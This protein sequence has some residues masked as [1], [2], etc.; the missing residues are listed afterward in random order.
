M[1]YGQKRLSLAD[2]QIAAQKLRQEIDK[3]KNL[4]VSQIGS[5]FWVIFVNAY[6]YGGF[7]L[8]D[9]VNSIYH[10]R[11]TGQFPLNLDMIRK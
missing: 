4:E 8:T 6:I 7:S 10:Y 1:Q 3:H 5:R 9:I 2:E 11:R